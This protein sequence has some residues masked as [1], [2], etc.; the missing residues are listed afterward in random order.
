MLKKYTTF[1]LITFFFAC[2]ESTDKVE[3]GQKQNFVF[4][5]VDDLGW[6]DLGYSGS[7]FYETPNI[8]ELSKASIKFTN[9]YASAS[10]CSPSRAAI[11]TGNTL[12][13]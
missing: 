5:L 3:K 13:V 4:V 1:L 7:S 2:N 12:P 9:A 6:T 11:V 8:D 10:I